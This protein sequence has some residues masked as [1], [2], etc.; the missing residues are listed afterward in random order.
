MSDPAA[1]TIAAWLPG[2][3]TSPTSS[4]L[5]PAPAAGSVGPVSTGGVV[6][7]TG[8]RP[9]AASARLRVSAVMVSVLRIWFSLS[10]LQRGP[11]RVGAVLRGRKTAGLTAGHWHREQA[12]A[13]VAA[14]AV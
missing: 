9:Q 7:G 3:S 11:A 2:S 10:A 14:E 4:A 12:R 1:A 13:P 8:L 6:S 5:A